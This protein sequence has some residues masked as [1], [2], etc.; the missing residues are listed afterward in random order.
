MLL[1]NFGEGYDDFTS[2]ENL[3]VRLRSL[4]QGVFR[5]FSI[6]FTNKDHLKEMVTHSISL[7]IG[8]YEKVEHCFNLKTGYL[9]DKTEFWDIMR[10][11]GYE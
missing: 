1:Y 8:F 9:T 4:V 11:L 5:I 2:S 7:V 10:N 3:M 6:S